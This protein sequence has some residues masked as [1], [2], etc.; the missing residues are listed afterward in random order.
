MGL[1]ISC[2]QPLSGLTSDLKIALLAI[3][4]AT[5]ALMKFELVVKFDFSV[6]FC[7]ALYTTEW[8]DRQTNKETGLESDRDGQI[9]SKLTYNA[10][11]IK[12]PPN[13]QQKNTC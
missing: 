2:I 11:I 7:S 8:T 9:D 12:R 5:N 3:H 10:A 1:Q 13:E 6:K 4:T